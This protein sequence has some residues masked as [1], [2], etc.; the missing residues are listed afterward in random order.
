M[1]LKRV[2]LHDLGPTSEMLG[3]KA[4]SLPCTG[5]ASGAV[6]KTMR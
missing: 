5:R 2:L 4:A 3:V 6:E 1:I